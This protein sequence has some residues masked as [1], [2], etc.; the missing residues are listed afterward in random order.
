MGGCTTNSVAT[1]NSGIIAVGISQVSLIAGGRSD[2]Y[3]PAVNLYVSANIVANGDIISAGFNITGN[4]TVDC[5][6]L[7]SSIKSPP[8]LELLVTFT[9][10]PAATRSRSVL[11][12]TLTV[13][14]AA[15]TPRETL[16]F[17]VT[18][19][20]AVVRPPLIIPFTVMFWLKAKTSPFTVP[21]TGIFEPNR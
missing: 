9:S 8:M 14:L 5:R 18:D 6:V 13:C 12:P 19:W 17:I 3:L 2:G 7:R 16:P 11:P 4:T 10:L 1:L 21:L 20:P 15:G